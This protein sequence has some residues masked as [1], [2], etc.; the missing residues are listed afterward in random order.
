MGVADPAAAAFLRADNTVR[1]NL[2]GRGPPGFRRNHGRPQPGTPL[3]ARWAPDDSGT[4]RRLV[5]ERKGE[6]FAP[7]SKPPP[8]LGAPAWLVA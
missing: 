7:A 5:V 1:Q 8:S 3:T 6:G 4:F 2:L